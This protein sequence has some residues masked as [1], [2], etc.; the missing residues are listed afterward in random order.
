[1]QCIH[2]GRQ[3]AGRVLLHQQRRILAA[4]GHRR[5]GPCLHR[6]AGRQVER[7]R[8]GHRHDGCAIEGQASAVLALGGPG[9]GVEAGGIVVPGRIA[10]GGAGPLVKAIGSDEACDGSAADGDRHNIRIAAEV[11]DGITRTNAIAIGGAG[12]EANVEVAGR[13]RGGN[14]REGGAAGPLAALHLIAGHAD[15]IGRG[16]PT[17]IE[18]RPVEHTARE[19]ARRGRWGAVAGTPAHRGRHILLNFTRAQGAV[20]D[21]NFVEDAVKILAAKE[22]MAANT[23]LPE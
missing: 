3:R 23:Q 12:R 2:M 13:G 19:P 17:Q 9:R 14:E 6:D 15:V 16:R 22:S 11:A 4:A 20:I 18:L 10:T 1:M 8:I 21:P 7:C 5:K